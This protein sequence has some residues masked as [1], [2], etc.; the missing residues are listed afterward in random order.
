MLERLSVVRFDFKHC[1]A[2]GVLG[3]ALHHSVEAASEVPVSAAHAPLSA[4][5]ICFPDL[6]PKRTQFSKHARLFAFS[7][8]KQA[9]LPAGILR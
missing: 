7:C 8:V 3:Q 9:P 5:L 1:R 6:H 2:R 4:R